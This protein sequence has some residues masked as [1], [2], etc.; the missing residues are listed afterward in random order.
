[1]ESNSASISDLKNSLP[2][3]LTCTALKKESANSLCGPC[4]KCG[5]NDRFVFKT[6]T[7]KS[8]CRQCKPEKQSMD[9]I[10]FH[11]WLYGKQTKDLFAEYLPGNQKRLNNR[12]HHYK[13]GSPVKIYPYHDQDGSILYHVCRFEPKKFRPC[14]PGGKW[15]V[16]GIKPVPYNLPA[17]AKVDT[18]FICEGEK[19][20]DTIN[21]LGLTGTCKANWTG[22]WNQ[23]FTE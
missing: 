10:D 14:D 3:I 16:K 13:L 4:P 15:K 18:V 9:I 22:K 5:G 8:W 6:D 23:G 12:F 2:G 1:M 20:A 17:M 7:G 11:C 19:D 21:N